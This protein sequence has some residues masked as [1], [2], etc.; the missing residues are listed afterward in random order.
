MLNTSAI[1]V[2]QYI[3]P[4][5]LL[6]LAATAIKD[7]ENGSAATSS[8][9][10]RA[11]RSTQRLRPGTLHVSTPGRPTE[12]TDRRPEQT[13]A[14]D[15]LYRCDSRRAAAKLSGST[16]VVPKILILC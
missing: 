10:K 6:I 5:I 9:L 7:T 11:T 2:I 8:N 16:S 15:N 14:R 13:D 3:R 12:C 1:A 4:H